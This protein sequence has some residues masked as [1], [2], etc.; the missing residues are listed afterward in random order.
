MILV[1]W[2]ISF[3]FGVA[4][5]IFI[6]PDISPCFQLIHTE[7]QSERCHDY[8]E[9]FTNIPNGLTGNLQNLWT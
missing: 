6:Y 2:A 4:F 5:M 3:V 7:T 1:V 8:V 9:F